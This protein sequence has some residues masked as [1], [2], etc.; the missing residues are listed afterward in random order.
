MPNSYGIDMTPVSSSNVAEVGYDE[1][2]L[3]LYVRFHSGLLYRYKGVT[4]ME[5]DGLRSAPSVGSYLHRN[6]KNAFPYE[7]V[8]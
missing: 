7:R 1:K 6:I 5:F 2:L 8:E 3:L 4:R